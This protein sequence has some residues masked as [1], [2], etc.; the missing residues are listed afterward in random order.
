M[1]T[2]SEL[3][4]IG[5]TG[6]Q[7]FNAG[8]YEAAG[9]AF[10]AAAEG[11]A[12][13]GDSLNAAEQRN[14]LSVTLLKLR[15]PQEALEQVEGTEGV[16]AAAGDIKRHGMSLNNRAAALQDLNRLDEALSSYERAAALLGDAG[17]GE[18]RGVVLKAAAAIQLRRGRL[19]DSGLSMLGA[20]GSGLKP[21]FLERA[22]RSLLRRLP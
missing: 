12:K 5:E 3:M 2:P 6:K 7:A 17:E 16:F 21:T 15:R 20:L 1:T 9:E 18:L 19:R 11:Y 14:N 22:L 4:K 10:R 13:L 8:R